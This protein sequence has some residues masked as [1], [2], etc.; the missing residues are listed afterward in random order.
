M[1]DVQVLFPFFLGERVHVSFQVLPRIFFT[2]RFLDPVQFL[3][4]KV[5]GIEPVPVG[6]YPVQAADVRG[7]FPGTDNF[8][9][10]LAVYISAVVPVHPVRGGEFSELVFQE[11]S[12]VRVSFGVYYY[13]VIHALFITGQG[14]G[15][16]YH[17]QVVYVGR[18]QAR[19]PFYF[20]ISCP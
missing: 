10:E 13:R 9:P 6:I 11:G 1:R 4:R 5:I 14:Q 8:R 12:Q 3:V 20:C 16:F 18:D 19:F 17:D 15:P 2:V 7:R